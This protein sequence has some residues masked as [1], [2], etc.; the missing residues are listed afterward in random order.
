MRP[1]IILYCHR[2]STINLAA[3]LG[4]H[5]QGHFLLHH[6]NQNGNWQMLLQQSHQNRSGNIVRQIGCHLK[7]FVP[8]QLRNIHFENISRHNGNIII[9]FQRVGQHCW[10]LLVQLH[11]SY[12]GARFC[13]SL[14]QST[15]TWPNLQDI[16]L[17]P[18]PGCIHNS[19]NNTCIHQEILSQLLGRSQVK[20][21][22]NMPGNLGIGDYRM[23]GFYSI[24]HISLLLYFSSSAT[25][26]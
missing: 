6:S 12:L 13:Q 26:C 24:C 5:S 21:L 10:Q 17:R 3:W 16:V 25:A 15:N 11:C 22:H 18:C 9:A 7:G 19:L 20:G 4:N 8:H 14:S 23:G 1:G 2:Q